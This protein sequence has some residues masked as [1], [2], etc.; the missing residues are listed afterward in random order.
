MVLEIAR[1]AARGDRLDS[2]LWLVDADGPGMR[3]LTRSGGRNSSPAFAPDGRSLFFLAGP[4]SGPRQVVRLTLG[5][6]HQVP[7]TRSPIDVES[8]VLSRDGRYLA[9]SATVFPGGP[10][11][12]A[13]TADRL[14]GRGGTTGQ[15]ARP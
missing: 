11:T 15:R 4:P 8:F 1:A 5:S 14:T 3:R 6:E 2:H 7:V 12:L 13:A 9:F 10:D